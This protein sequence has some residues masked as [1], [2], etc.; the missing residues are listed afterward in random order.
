MEY[1]IIQSCNLTNISELSAILQ[2]ELASNNHEAH[3][4][5]RYSNA[6][7][8]NVTS[9]KNYYFISIDF[10]LFQK[11]YRIEIY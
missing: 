5:H 8:N 1:N 4:L 7:Y 6:L 10:Q 3:W 2:N 9:G 11:R